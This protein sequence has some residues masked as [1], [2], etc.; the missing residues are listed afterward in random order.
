MSNQELT[1]T[2]PPSVLPVRSGVYE[3]LAADPETLQAIGGFDWG[4]SY[5]DATDRVWGCAHDTIDEAW[6]HPEYEFAHQ[7]KKWRGLT[8]EPKA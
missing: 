2:F 7:C 5:F 6:Q 8:E 1:P 4:Y 3:T